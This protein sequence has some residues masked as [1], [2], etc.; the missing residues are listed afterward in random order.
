MSN[1]CCNELQ[2]Q[3][4]FYTDT[5][6]R[7]IKRVWG[8]SCSEVIQPDGRCQGLRGHAGEHWCFRLDGVYQFKA[9]GPR[10]ESCNH[11]LVLPGDPRYRTPLEMSRYHYRSHYTESEVTD[12]EELA[13]QNQGG[14]VSGA[15][16]E[17]QA[18]DGWE[19]AGSSEPDD[20]R[21]RRKRAAEVKYDQVDLAAKSTVEE[22]MKRFD[23]DVERFSN[24]ETGQSATIDAPLAMQLITEAAVRLTPNIERVLDIGCGAGNN[25]LKLQQVYGKPFASDLL[26]LSGPMLE[27][28]KQRVI[29]SGIDTVTTWLA[30]IRD[31][32]LPKSSYDVVLAAAVLHHLRDDE[33]WQGTFEKIISVLR[34]GGS[35]WI[36]DLVV[37][38]TTPVHELMWSRY[39]DYLDGLG[40]V[41]YRQKVFAYIA[42]E[43]SPRSVTY[44]LD[45]LRRVGFAHVELLH[46]NS[47]FAAFGAWKA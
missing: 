29:A 43:D 21:L 47:C 16:G 32:D 39:A 28:A 45:L 41:E 30:D 18:R 44:Q 37:H 38:E 34:P 36:T 17:C 14:A 15:G 7:W 8:E 40:G 20:H 10:G 13:R 27:R 26:D 31:A 23:A 9:Q 6:G 11:G 5:Q 2:P 4:T 24:L 19:Q 46:K 1:D 12:P 42:R 3:P 35:F 33:D 22:I 25:T